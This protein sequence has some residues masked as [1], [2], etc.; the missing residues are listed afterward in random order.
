MIKGA[1]M[2]MEAVTLQNQVKMEQNRLLRAQLAEDARYAAELGDPDCRQEWLVPQR[3]SQYM[4]A[5]GQR[6]YNSFTDD[7]LLDILRS[8]ASELGRPPTQK[9][10]F[11]VYRSYIRRRFGNWPT[12]LRA[13]GLKAPKKRNT[14]HE[15]D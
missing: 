5:S 9:D 13:A 7:E 10:I 15:K 14:D 3:W 12:A 8:S 4:G 1:S 11:C 2:H 6:L